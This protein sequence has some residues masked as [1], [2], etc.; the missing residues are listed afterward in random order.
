MRGVPLSLTFDSLATAAAQLPQIPHPVLLN[1]S[2]HTFSLSVAEDDRSGVFSSVKAVRYVPASVAPCDELSLP[3]FVQNASVGIWRYDLSRRF[4]RR[5]GVLLCYRSL[6]T[7]WYLFNTSDAFFNQAVPLGS[8]LSTSTPNIGLG[9]FQTCQAALLISG[10]QLNGRED[11]FFYVGARDRCDAYNATMSPNGL[12]PVSSVQLDTTNFAFLVNVSFSHVFEDSG[13][14]RLCALLGRAAQAVEI[15][16]FEVRNPIQLS[17]S[18]I[19][20][21]CQS[22][23]VLTSPVPVEYTFHLLFNTS[24]RFMPLVDRTSQAVFTLDAMPASGFA[25][26]VAVF[27]PQLGSE[28]LLN[29]T[30]WFNATVFSS[31]VSRAVYCSSG[32]SQKV[33]GSPT[34][35]FA[36]AVVFLVSYR[37]AVCGDLFTEG[38]ITTSPIA[39]VNGAVSLANIVPSLMWDARYFLLLVAALLQ[40][41]TD[42]GARLKTLLSL[43]DPAALFSGNVS[44]TLQ[45]QI[46]L[47]D[48]VAEYL[49]SNPD[50]ALTLLVM[51]RVVDVYAVCCEH[52]PSGQSLRSSARSSA[53]GVSKDFNAT[54]AD[55]GDAKGDGGGF[56]SLPAPDNITAPVCRGL[57]MLP[58]ILKSTSSSS[59]SRRSG[60][61]TSFPPGTPAFNLSLSIVMSDVPI[62]TFRLGYERNQSTVDVVSGY[63]YYPSD[64]S[65]KDSKSGTWAMQGHVAY[66]FQRPTLTINVTNSVPTGNFAIFSGIATQIFPDPMAPRIRREKEVLT[67]SG[68]YILLAILL[69]QI[70]GLFSSAWY[71]RWNN[72][73]RLKA[74]RDFIYGQKSTDPTFFQL[75]RLLA[76]FADLNISLTPHE[77]VGMLQALGGSALDGDNPVVALH[78]PSFHPTHCVSTVA[79]SASFG[80]QLLCLALACCFTLRQDVAPQVPFLLADWVGLGIVAAVVSW[81]FGVWTRVVLLRTQRDLPSIAGSAAAIASLIVGGLASGMAVLP[82][83]AALLCG[84]TLVYFLVAFFFRSW[85]ST[86]N[87]VHVNTVVRTVGSMLY[88]LAEISAII[89]LFF[90]PYFTDGL[91]I[92]SS[93]PYLGT[94][95]NNPDGNGLWRVFLFALFID[96]FLFETVKSLVLYKLHQLTNSHR[97]KDRRPLHPHAPTDIGPFT[98]RLSTYSVD[99]PTKSLPRTMEEIYG[100]SGTKEVDSP[101][102]RL[103][104]LPAATSFRYDPQA[105]LIEEVA[106]EGDD[107]LNSSDFE[108]V[109][110]AMSNNS[111]EGDG[112]S[113]DEP[114]PIR[115]G[116]SSASGGK[117][118]KE[119]FADIPRVE[120]FSAAK[121]NPLRQSELWT[122]PP[123]TRPNMRMQQQSAPFRLV[124]TVTHPESPSDFDYL[125]TTSPSRGQ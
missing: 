89:I 24:S 44:E 47:V 103:S 38:S 49:A 111:D 48:S 69:Y 120:S 75:H 117:I 121:P 10:Y 106:G 9:L 28:V 62:T 125:D 60:E 80:M 67:H 83:L 98:K 3:L 124:P 107:D 18:T 17:G 51:Q 114:P 73:R 16:V 97:W 34:S 109:F 78:G 59:S 4:V 56:V 119:P 11:S 54:R 25:L 40:L 39:A 7:R 31:K 94:D 50:P 101:F 27:Q 29:V 45:G 41:D 71:D 81:P 8:S 42:P 36:S 14:M 123:S 84:G 12:L 79:K 85:W 76:F 61:A 82:M 22:N 57:A 113:G 88:L 110:P 95:P 23:L 99:P 118:Q 52:L 37:H 116:F 32:L 15:G 58:N 74:A 35:D 102:D 33:R 86:L 30:R 112:D 115:D 66:T 100:D 90:V 70:V 108:P 122:M 68:Y 26:R 91:T 13:W 64:A 20:L 1:P 63:R 43:T 72:T 104:P 65:L 19:S 6:S 105:G 93:Q 5:G 46:A 21:A 96:L 77:Q 87:F 92:Y 2:L 55:A 53:M